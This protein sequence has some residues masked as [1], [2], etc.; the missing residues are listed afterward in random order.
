MRD[1]CNLERDILFQFFNNKPSHISIT[2]LQLF[3]KKFIQGE[4]K[5]IN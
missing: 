3:Q 5:T 1:A 4:Q 2:Y